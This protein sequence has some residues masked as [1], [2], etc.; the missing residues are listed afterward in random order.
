M[1]ERDCLVAT[2]QQDADTLNAAHDAQEKLRREIRDLN[3]E[4]Y[5]AAAQSAKAE[6]HIMELQSL[7]KEMEVQLEATSDDFTCHLLLHQ[8]EVASAKRQIIDRDHSIEELQFRILVLEKSMDSATLAKDARIAE[9]EA[10]FARESTNKAKCS[11]LETDLN[12]ALYT[13]TEKDGTITIL[14]DKLHTA[15]FEHDELQIQLHNLKKG[16]DGLRMQL[17]EKDA[18]LVAA[19][20]SQV[21]YEIEVTH[22]RRAV[23]DAEE[24]LVRSIEDAEK[25]LKE[26][27]R[28]IQ[29]NEAQIQDYQSQL[30]SHT[31]ALEAAVNAS[32]TERTRAD[33]ARSRVAT[34]MSEIDRLKIVEVGLGKQVE[35]LRRVS[36]FDEFKRLELL[37]HLKDLEKDK[38]LLNIALDSK[39]TE[40]ILLQRSIRAPDMTSRRD[41]RATTSLSASTQG[42]KQMRSLADI[43]PLPP[44]RLSTSI[45]STPVHSKRDSIVP[46]PT[47]PR[48]KVRKPLS[49]ST[50]QNME[51][52]ANAAAEKS[53]V[54]KTSSNTKTGLTR[55]SSLPALVPKIPTIVARVD[56]VAEKVEVA[57]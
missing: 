27:S 1:Q 41:Q 56:D 10:G 5:E 29:Q 47:T 28:V 18:A 19:S 36:S 14:S 7:H 9:L 39:Q 37:K 12:D 31:K 51:G 33:D 8:D 26:Q 11:K 2:R 40:L 32:A 46:S 21:Y 48:S 15:K 43:T 54:H 20:S 34:Y 53:V 49:A 25:E 4:K 17:E 55:R 50:K 30:Q 44:R 22:L 57:N 6:R 13:V 35:D 16:A 23:A 24:A 45:S 3:I 42:I 38:D 52:K